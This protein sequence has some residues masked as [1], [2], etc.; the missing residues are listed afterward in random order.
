MSMGLCC[1]VFLHAAE[2]LEVQRSQAVSDF[3]GRHFECEIVLR[4]VR[5]YC[6]YGIGD[7]DLEQMM[8]ER[9]VTADHSTIYRRMRNHA[10]EIGKRLRW[11]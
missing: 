7:R 1:K 4:A 9:G 10:P 11:Q 2:W 5:R 3:K 6:R 8:V